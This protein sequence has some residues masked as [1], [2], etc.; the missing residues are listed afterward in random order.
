MLE[1][2]SPLEELG[3]NAY[4]RL[5]EYRADRMAV[6]EGYGDQ[7][8]SGLKKLNT[9]GFGHLAPSKAQVVVEYNHPPLSERI[10]AIEEAQKKMGKTALLQRFKGLGEMNPEQL[11]DTAMDPAKRSLTRVTIEDAASADKRI[12]VLMG[13]DSTIRKDYIYKHA[14]FNKIDSFKIKAEE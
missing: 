4:M 1:I 14:D 2:I 7:L 10:T 13:D 6:E 11:W 8:I 3:I 9:E 12:T 5:C